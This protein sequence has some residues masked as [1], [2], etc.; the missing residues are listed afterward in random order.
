MS[1]EMLSGFNQGQM[2]TMSVFQKDIRMVWEILGRGSWGKEAE[3]SGRVV[4]WRRS[5]GG[6]S[7]VL[8]TVGKGAER[9]LNLD[10]ALKS[11]R[12]S[13]VTQWKQ[14]MRENKDT[15]QTPVTGHCRMYDRVYL[16]L[17][18]SLK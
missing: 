13:F 11:E 18:F 7:P 15:S 16:G 9:A 4:S 5:Q 14:R 8:S 17:S 10:K 1:C 12:Q 2:A 3:T 6:K